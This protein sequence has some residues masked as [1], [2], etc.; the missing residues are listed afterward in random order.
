MENEVIRKL[1][2]S[3]PAEQSL[4]GA[5]L[6]DPAVLNEVAALMRADD[7]YLEEHKQIYLA[8]QELFLASREIDVVTLIDTLVKKGVYD[9]SGGEDYIRSLIDAGAD[10]PNARDYARIIKEKSVLRQLI[11]ASNE[12]S[13][14]AY[15]EQDSVSAVLDH[16]ENL[17]FQIAQG[18]D[19]KNFRH[20]REVIQTVY[21]NLKELREN[22]EAAQGLKTGFSHLDKVLA[23]IG[24]TD[25]VLVGA[26][27][28]MGKTA[29]ALNIAT[30]VAKQS[31]KKV[32]V[33]SLEMSAE[34]L[35]TRVLASEA[36]VNSYSLR[37][38]ELNAQD[39][40]R[41]AVAAGELSGCDLLIDDTT[42][43]TVTAMKAKL[44]REK[45]LGLVVI[46]YLGLMDGDSFKDNRVQQVSAISRGLKIMAK[47]L[48]VPILCCAQLSRSPDKNAGKD[49]RPQLS[50][51]RDSGAIEQDA[52][53]VIFL[54]RSE[55]Y[56]KEKRNSNDTSV[57][58]VII[59][60]NRHGALA[61]VHMGWNGQYT[62]FITVE[63]GLTEQ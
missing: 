55:Y 4:L 20:I 36:L 19:T 57:A 15:S 25:L 63:E 61:N 53:T 18:R 11:E 2:F 35:T 8:M 22:P 12:I 59:A 29:F 6:I 41:L 39:W 38:G 37:T 40:E 7:F 50:D 13:E 58:E 30:N 32:C 49:H 31:K 21:E 24:K 62:K 16:A 51:L 14:R 52:D 26:R 47:E 17:I 28:G 48:E 3:M 34:Q 60:K 9:K 5:I 54:Y 46:D 33:F 44:R 23:G 43:L 42:G 45:N 27:P 56:D 10:A 1:P